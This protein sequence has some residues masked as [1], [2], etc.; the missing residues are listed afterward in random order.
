MANTK[1]SLSLA[2]N[3]KQTQLNLLSPTIFCYL[4]QMNLFI[5]LLISRSRMLHCHLIFYAH[6]SYFIFM[7]KPSFFILFILK[8]ISN[9][10][11]VWE[12]ISFSMFPT[13][14][15]TVLH[16]K[17]KDP[18]LLYIPFCLS[19]MHLGSNTGVELSATGDYFK[20][21]S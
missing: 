21:K 2:L 1:F 12:L 11:Y 10:S 14:V 5:L 7:F 19:Q 4:S 17:D 9:S 16:P 6:L 13:K 8:Q 15:T 3:R 18:L 20:Q